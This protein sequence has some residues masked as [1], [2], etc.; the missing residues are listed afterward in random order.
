MFPRNHIRKMRRI[1]AH[2]CKFVATGSTNAS[3][4]AGTN[5]GSRPWTNESISECRIVIGW[6]SRCC[7]PLLRIQLTALASHSRVRLVVLFYRIL[8]CVFCNAQHTI[9]K[10][11][12]HRF[13]YSMSHRQSIY[14]SYRLIIECNYIQWIYISG[15]EY[16]GILRALGFYTF[17]LILFFF[18]NWI[19]REIFSLEIP[20]NWITWRIDWN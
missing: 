16:S 12:L 4:N 15:L 6:H 14:D 5:N 7:I 11:I 13:F 17:L 18:H 9:M 1:I 2:Q 19:T 10:I 8:Q 3:G 20:P